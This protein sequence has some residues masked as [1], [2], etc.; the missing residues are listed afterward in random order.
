MS[1][2]KH[3]RKLETMYQSAPINGIFRPTLK[4]SSG[5]AVVRAEARSD[6]FHAAGALHGAVYF[7]MLDDAAFFAASSLVEGYFMLTKTFSLDFLQPVSAGQ[8][9]SV[10]TVVSHI[11]RKV[12]CEA[13]LYADEL[14]VARGQGVFVTSRTKL[15]KE[16]GYR[17]D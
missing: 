10:G 1:T 4:I 6:L 17:L 7:K 5:Q 11:G 14:E 12:E 3:F 2:A 16:L 8:L 15:K 13:V 9:R